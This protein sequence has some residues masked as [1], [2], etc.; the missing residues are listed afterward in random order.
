MIKKL[1]TSIW[2]YFVGDP[3]YIWGRTA[4]CNDRLRKIQEMHR[5]EAK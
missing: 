2:H 5:K 3:N 4:W 1:L